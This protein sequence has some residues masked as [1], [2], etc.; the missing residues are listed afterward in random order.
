M[1]SASMIRLSAFL[2]GWAM[3]ASGVALAQTTQDNAEKEIERYREM[4]SDPMSNPGF[5]AVDR[6]EA[7]WSAKRGTKEVSLET[8]DL[9]RGPGKLDG[10]Y[11]TLPRYFADADRVMDI[12][13]RLLWCMEKIQGLDTADVRRRRFGGPDYT[14]DMQDLVAYIA[15]KSTGM[16]YEPQTSHPKEKEMLQAGEALFFR[17]AGTMDFSCATCHGDDGKRIRLQALPNFSKPGKDARETMGGWPTYRGFAEPVAHHAAPPLGLLSPDAHARAGIRIRRPDRAHR[18]YGENGGR[19]RNHR[20]VDQALRGEMMKSILIFLALAGL[21][22]Q[23]Q[24]QVSGKADPATVEKYVDSMWAKA[25]AEWK[26]APVQDETQRVCTQTRNTPPPD[27]FEKILKREKAAVVF[28]AD[29]KVIGD[30]KAGQRVANTGTGGQFTDRSTTPHGGNCYACHQMARTE[31]SYGTLGPS[32]QNYGKD[33]KYDPA[34]ARTAYAKIFDAQSVF[35][36]SQMPRF[37]VHK[38]LSEQ[39][40]K[41]AV[42]FLFDPESPVNK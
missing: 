4:I 26:S 39:Q 17:R 9:G 14:S 18:L 27:E 32:L 3:L 7:L 8:C 28:P 15:N 19:R 6:G 23:A 31:L 40:M 24:A 33:R 35:P 20:A 25:P 41:D 30:W 5:L 1:K 13:Q 2:M 12:E 37:G 21:V 22:T 36:C 10:A 38:F 34:E 16:K 11:A 29:G 42:A